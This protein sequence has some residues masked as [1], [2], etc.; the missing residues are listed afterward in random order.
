MRMLFTL[1]MGVLG[2]VL[3]IYDITITDWGF[4]VIILC[5]ASNNLFGYLQE[6]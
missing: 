4:W 1:S 6:D 5:A 3:A 2:V